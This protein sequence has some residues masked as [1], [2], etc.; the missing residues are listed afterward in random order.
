MIP[1]AEL[2]FRFT[3]SRGPGGQNVNK[4]AT[5]VVLLF[6]VFASKCLNPAQQ[7]RIRR[8]LGG[9]LNKEGVLQIVCSRDRSQEA[10]RRGAIELFQRLLGDA[11][12]PRKLRRTTKP[13]QA[14]IERRRVAKAAQSRRKALRRSSFER[15]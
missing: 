10:N 3:T 13:T 4:V 6:D 14:S 5:K 11:L 2:R 7:E 15:E 8:A 12:R 1:E 9:R